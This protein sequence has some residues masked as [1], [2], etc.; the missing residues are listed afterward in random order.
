MTIDIKTVMLEHS[1]AKVEL[2]TTYFSTYLNILSRVEYINKIHIYDLMCGEGVYKD[3]SKGSPVALIEKI[4]DHYFSHKKTCPNIKLWFNDN[5]ISEIDTSK[6]KIER[7]REIVSK[8]FKPNNVEVEYTDKNY[9]EL[10]PIIKNKLDSLNNEKALLFIDPYGY[11]EIKPP[12]IKDFLIGGNAEIILF[13]PVSHMYRF[14]KKSLSNDDFPSGIPLKEFLESL[15][16]ANRKLEDSNSVMGFIEN[17]KQSFRGFLKEYTIFTDTFTIERN[18]NN[19]FSL[20]FFTSNA[21]GFEKMLDAKWH[22][23]EN[24]GKGFRISSQ[25]SLFSESDLSNYPAKLKEYIQSGIQ[26]TNKDIYL[27]GLL[28]GFLPKHTVVVFRN[29]QKTD[30]KFKVYQEDGKPA[31]KGSFYI[32]YKN[33]TSNPDKRIIFKFE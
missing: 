12:H 1:K 19:I 6:K 22:L 17:L 28:N 33:Y 13:L 32:S 16:A 9:L 3:K 7:V 29:W 11:K 4:K 10:Y 20:F 27:F 25:Q 18:R 8:K 5:G 21:L 30:S 23:D 31:R 2:Y 24:R 14:A 26:P 15:F